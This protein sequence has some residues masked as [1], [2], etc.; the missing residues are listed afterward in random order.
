MNIFGNIGLYSWTELM[1]CKVNLRQGYV[2]TDLSFVPEYSSYLFHTVKSTSPQTVLISG[3]FPA[4]DISDKW[5]EGYR[6]TARY[7][8]DQWIIVMTEGAQQQRYE[9]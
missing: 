5:N 1:S 2:I 4:D 7:L 3:E 9:F 8:N 6:I